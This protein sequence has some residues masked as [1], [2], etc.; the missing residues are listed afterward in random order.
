MKIKLISKSFCEK[1]A[2]SVGEFDISAC[3]EFSVIINRHVGFTFCASVINKSFCSKNPFSALI[4]CL[5]SE[6]IGMA[7]Y[8]KIKENL[9]SKGMWQKL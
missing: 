5:E 8:D 7:K 3:I 2:W 1:S 6:T 9:R 4:N